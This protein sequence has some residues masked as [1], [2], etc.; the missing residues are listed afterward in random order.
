MRQP[1]KSS[2]PPPQKLRRVLTARDL[3]GLGLG[4]IIGTGIFV[5]S[6]VAAAR[7]AGPGVTL[8]FVLA[9]VASALAA[10]VYAELAAMFP[11]AG[12][13][14]AYSHAAFGEVFAWLIGW[15]LILE[16]TVA[17]AAV[18]LGWSGYFLDVLKGFHLTLPREIT[19]SPFAGGI[20]NITPLLV[21]GAITYLVLTGAKESSRANIG[22]VALKLGAIFLFLALGLPRFRVTNWHPFL[23]FGP[24][25]VVRGA[26]IILFAY[27][28]FDAVATAAE[29]VKN[30]RR[31]LPLGI[32]GSLIIS[33]VIYLAVT[34]TLTGM[35]KYD[36]LD[37]PSPVADALAL[38]G[39]GWAASL[40]SVGALAGLTSVL[41]VN[42]F[43]QSRI[44]YAMARDGLL[45]PF[46]SR[47]HPKY[48]TPYGSI[49]AIGGLAGILSALLPIH[50]IAELANIG[51]L[52]AFAAVS[53]GVIV[54]RYTQPE[55][56]RP[57]KAPF[58]PFLPLAS[59]A[60]TVLLMLN[61]P[62]LTWYRF[63]LWIAAGL[64]LYCGY[65][66]R[67]SRLPKSAVPEPSAKV[68]PRKGATSGS[69]RP[70]R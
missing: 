14:Y 27:I 69:G 16:Y 39:L 7:Y 42:F 34:A 70:R 13:A 59:F 29:E 21:T 47:L 15:N 32:L 12:S 38:R 52:S 33:T 1:E 46:F 61:L 43:A 23:P 6:G 62:A 28:G 56:P 3:V 10:L 22:V 30:P 5:L 31:D 53:L 2:A 50:T 24:L 67:H 20:V 57:F 63:L 26:A 37:T 48:G 36:R 25:G 11:T 9:G 44:L 41:I 55:R 66:L 18:A 58:F 49:L 64:A 60:A 54:L 4:A 65:G 68:P 19:A 45:P 8:S 40:V 35:V 51:T 17:A